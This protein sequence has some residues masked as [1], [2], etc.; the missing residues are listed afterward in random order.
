[1]K[2]APN[3]GSGPLFMFIA[4]L[5]RDEETTVSSAKRR[6]DPTCAEMIPT[7][8]KGRNA[9]ACFTKVSKRNGHVPPS[10]YKDARECHAAAE[11]VR[12]LFTILTSKGS[13]MS[14]LPICSNRLK[15]GVAIC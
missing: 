5:S 7:K 15:W 8:A 4:D 14:S 2:H 12:I 3:A 10:H 13:L 11:P 9:D 1:M 6:T